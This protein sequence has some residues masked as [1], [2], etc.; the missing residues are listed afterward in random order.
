MTDT[1]II[2]DLHLSRESPRTLGLFFRF[3]DEQAR[4]ARDLYILGDLFD[5]WIGDDDRS[6]PVPEII[7][8]LRATTDSGCSIHFM[9]GNRDFL[10]GEEF[11]RET[12]CSLLD[13]PAVVDLYGIPTLLMHGD[14]LCSDDLEY[15]AARRFLR[16]PAF[17]R[18]FLGKS[19]PERIAIAAGYRKKS[20][21]VVS[22]QAADIM[23]V[24]QQTVEIYMREQGVTR[25]IH[26]HTH[27]PAIHRFELDGRPARRI[28]LEDWHGEHGNFLRINDHG[29]WRE[30]L[31]SCPV[32]R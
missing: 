21:E 25:L 5:A 29:L 24:N 12:G 3:L 15:Q 30:S 11:A 6:D 9:H 14:L 8:R 27:R 10:V 28:V 1:L 18:D 7:E 19:I 26:G 16:D 17:I 32:T 20:G 23:D 31:Q 22:R 4:G 2:S 13:D